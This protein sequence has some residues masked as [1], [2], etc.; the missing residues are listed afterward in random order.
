MLCFVFAVDM[1]GCIAFSRVG[2]FTVWTNMSQLIVFVVHCVYVSL[3]DFICIQS[4]SLIYQGLYFKNNKQTWSTLLRD[5]SLYYWARKRD[6]VAHIPIMAI[7]TCLNH[8]IK[9]KKSGCYFYSKMV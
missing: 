1:K 6:A 8:V 4:K 7:K 3:Y 2:L 9:H 5:R